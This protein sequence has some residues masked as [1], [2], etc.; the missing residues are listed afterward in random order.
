[1][2]AAILEL[3]MT[4]T[5]KNQRELIAGFGSNGQAIMDHY[6]YPESHWAIAESHYDDLNPNTVTLIYLGMDC[7]FGKWATGLHHYRS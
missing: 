5:M 2:T 7:C 4:M 1:M 3:Q 6:V